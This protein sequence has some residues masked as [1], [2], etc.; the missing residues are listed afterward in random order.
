MSDVHNL[1]THHHTHNFQ[2]IF[3]RM[4]VQW[5]IN[6]VVL[7]ALGIPLLG[8]PELRHLLVAR[9]AVGAAGNSMFYI[10]VTKLPLADATGTL[11]GVECSRER[12]GERESK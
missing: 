4:T 7:L 6:L 3:V 11:R 5:L 8:P 9:G 2:L 1:T 12:E 10:A